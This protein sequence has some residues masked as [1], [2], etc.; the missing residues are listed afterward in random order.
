M[1]AITGEIRVERLYIEKAAQGVDKVIIKIF[2]KVQVMN[3][4]LEI[5][6]QWSGKGT[7]SAP[8]KGTWSS[9]ISYNV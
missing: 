3:N 1:F 5:R 7:T 9:H 2:T 8:K 6:F 4:V